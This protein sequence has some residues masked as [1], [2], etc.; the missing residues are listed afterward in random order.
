MPP[1]TVQDKD[2]TYNKKSFYQSKINTSC[3]DV[4]Q[5]TDW[6]EVCTDRTGWKG[7][8]GGD[9]D[10]VMASRF[11]TRARAD[12]A[13]RFKRCVESAGGNKMIIRVTPDFISNDGTAKDLTVCVRP[14]TTVNK[15]IIFHPPEGIH[16]ETVTLPTM[17]NCVTTKITVDRGVLGS[18]NIP[19]SI[20]GYK[21]SFDIAVGGDVQGY[22]PKFM[23]E[24]NRIPQRFD[25]KI[26]LKL[27]PAPFSLNVSIDVP[28]GFEITPS[29]FTIIPEEDTFMVQVKAFVE[30]DL[31]KIPIA[32]SSVGTYTPI[33]KVE[34]VDL[35]VYEDWVVNYPES[36]CT[37]TE[38]DESFLDPR[39]GSSIAVAQD[40]NIL[41]VSIPNTSTF[42]APK[43]GSIAVYEF[44]GTC[45]D[46]LTVIQ[47]P[48]EGFD[49]DECPSMAEMAW[50]LDCTPDANRLV[51]G[52]QRGYKIPLPIGIC[53]TL[54]PGTALPPEELSDAPV[55]FTTFKRISSDRWIKDV[56]INQTP[57]DR[58]SFQAMPS[59]DDS[60]K[61]MVI[62][63][64]TTL[65]PDATNIS[66]LEYNAFTGQW[67]TVWTEP[68]VAGNRH[69]GRLTRDGKYIIIGDSSQ[70]K[71]VIYK[72]NIVGG[73]S[74]GVSLVWESTLLT[75]T[76]IIDTTFTKDLSYIF[77]GTMFTS[78][79]YIFKRESPTVDNW[80]LVQEINTPGGV[81]TGLDKVLACS[82]NGVFF[83]IGNSGPTS[84]DVEVYEKDVIEDVWTK[85]ISITH[86]NTGVFGES[87]RYNDS[88]GYLFVGSSSGYNGNGLVAV[89]KSN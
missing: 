58:Y 72:N 48:C 42:K 25:G 73:S 7:Y 29:K 24:P 46:R 34:L 40:A 70:D 68:L 50:H 13:G 41:F 47:N 56:T 26:S 44:N 80:S 78:K 82:D 74:T 51:C 59:I 89:Y 21:A 84:R 64:E 61:F 32:Y 33:N 45:W 20:N 69:T 15:K 23:F 28:E 85:K 43:T 65:A 11:R 6:C 88:K 76:N 62:R 31:Y 63:T 67:G 2:K 38:L 71:V 39:L 52:V 12:P 60:G 17:E 87:I 75:D 16:I 54:E 8:R 22:E 53:I 49:E 5:Q 3:P 79:K 86:P 57:S 14:P 30:G 4:Q 81:F 83:F 66:L 19:M 55:Y 18:Y 9:N 36:I 37:I 10:R 77:A 27:V 1:L 35:T